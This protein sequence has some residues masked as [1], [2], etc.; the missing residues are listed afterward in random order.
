MRG[1]E[2]RPPVAEPETTVTTT[3]HALDAAPPSVVGP[4]RG[5]LVRLAH[6]RAALVGAVLVGVVV[7]AALAAPLLTAVNGADPYAYH[8]DLLRGDSLPRGPLGGVSSRHWFGV[9]PR[10]GRDL[11]AIVLYGARTSIG[12]GVAATVLAVA[13]GVLVGASAAVAGG[14]WDKIVSRVVD[15]FFGFP[16]LIFI[17]AVGAFA[18]A[19]FP[20]PL[21]VLLVIALF[22]W[23][24]TARVV[25]AQ[26]L[27][28]TQR[29]FVRASRAQ[30]GGP[31]HVLRNQLLPNLAGTIIVVATMA[32]PANIGVEAALSFL[33][34]GV[35]PP[36]PSWGRTI[37]SA[38]QWVAT[39]PWYLLAPAGALAVVTLG[40]NLLGDA[41]RDVLDPRLVRT[42]RVRS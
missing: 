13:I 23:P 27:S 29:T 40:F 39:D 18:P 20:R 16:S 37:S 17:I 31:W 14:W 2:A 30:G 26:C 8:S 15:V 35:P 34:V 9:E 6:D 41:L 32:V 33:G 7:L 19:Y 38:I 36:T 24:G 11:F 3:E 28:L 25:R 4:P 22:G 5:V 12:V 1:D 42:R 10:T 21:L